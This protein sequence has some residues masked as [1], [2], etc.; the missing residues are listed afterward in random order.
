MG[1]AV[2][3]NSERK[4]L[5]GEFSVPAYYHLPTA[6]NSSDSC[7][8]SSDKIKQLTPMDLS[9]KLPGKLSQNVYV[10]NVL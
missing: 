2:D 5:E 10:N 8:E 9:N 6:K 3:L 4:E 1:I 7:A